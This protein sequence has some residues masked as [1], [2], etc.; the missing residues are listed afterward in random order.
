MFYKRNLPLSILEIDLPTITLQPGLHCHFHMNF[1][2]YFPFALLYLCKDLCYLKGRNSLEGNFAEICTS[3][4][5]SED[6]I[7]T[8]FKKK[9]VFKSHW[10]IKIRFK[11]Y[12]E[13][14][15]FHVVNF[16]KARKF[17]KMAETGLFWSYYMAI[18]SFPHPSHG[19]PTCNM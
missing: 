10:I 4:T 11:K 14:C 8:L 18:A 3:L 9:K 19:V 1:C 16:V 5:N 17:S 13:N 6:R 2:N 12:F 15:L 7:F